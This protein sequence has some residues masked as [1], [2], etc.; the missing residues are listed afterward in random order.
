MR[1]KFL[2]LV[3][4]CS[5]LA[6]MGSTA[7]TANAVEVE[8][9]SIQ[10]AAEFESSAADNV[11]KNTLSYKIENDG[12]VTITKYTGKDTSYTIPSKIEGKPVRTIGGSAFS[13]SHTLESV[14]IP[15]GVTVIRASAFDI[16]SNL[17][18]VSIPE[19]VTE[20]G[21]DAFANCEK[22]ERINIPSKVTKINSLAFANCHLL[23][24][25]TIPNGVTVIASH[26]F[27]NCTSL[28]N[29]T[30][31]ES[32]TN[33]S[34]AFEGCTA[35]KE[36]N[37]SEG[38]ETIGNETFRGCTSL[39]SIHI[40]KTV[41]KI[42]SAAFWNCTN[43]RGIAFN[44]D[45]TFFSGEI[46]IFK[47]CHKLTIYGNTGSNSEAYANKNSIQFK[48]LSEF[49]SDMNN[50]KTGDLDDDDKVT[51]AD[52]LLVLRHSVGLEYFTEREKK[53]ANVDND[54][55]ITSA[56][57]LCILRYSVGFKDKGT[58]FF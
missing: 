56:D 47:D 41:K 8:V 32:V 12:T 50:G 16:C 30:I 24:N 38:L 40:P 28:T 34:G 26:A 55:S 20:I 33:I 58:V 6:A 14:V 1:K 9:E 36:V 18:S 53:L 23:K 4:V 17:K 42:E 45:K 5:I 49:D 10:A 19:S 7:L 46:S 44:N 27:W 25:I 57:S 11:Y 2:S 37:L 21:Q 51:S 35:L 39:R 52:A 15:D 54:D 22:L 31:P 29:I 43:L 48:P 3:A 13:V